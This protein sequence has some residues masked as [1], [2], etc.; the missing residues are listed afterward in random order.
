[1]KAADIIGR[2]LADGV[3]LLSEYDSKRIF[4]E[5]GLT[6]AKEELAATESDALKNAL[7]IGLPVV[8]KGVGPDFAHKSE[9]GLVRV[10]VASEDAV[11]RNFRELDAAMDGRGRVLVQQV[12]SGTR[13]LM[14]GAIRDE[15]FGPVISFGLGGVFAEI[16]DDV[17]MRVAPMSLSD[18]EQMLGELRAS[19]ILGSFRGLPCVN[20]FKLA[21]DLVA[22]GQL[23]LDHPEISEIDINPLIVSSDC[24]IAVDGL[25][26]LST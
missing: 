18:A 15:Q 19:K 20:Q 12:V 3:N 25:I 1:M 26:V 10:G 23:C 22:I 4:A 21:R 6:I 14:I 5:Y 24:A 2:Y 7:A 11:V 17:S 13:E 16:L 8:M 9:F